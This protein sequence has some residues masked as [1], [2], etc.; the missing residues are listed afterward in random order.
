[1][2]S[3]GKRQNP[4][5]NPKMEIPGD[6]MGMKPR[7]MLKTEDDL[8]VD[9]NSLINSQSSQLKFGQQIEINDKSSNLL[10]NDQIKAPRIKQFL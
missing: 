1:M 10:K 6:N 5:S 8:V 7:K 2:S 3:L 4:N 9:L